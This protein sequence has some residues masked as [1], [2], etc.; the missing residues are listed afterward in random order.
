MNERDAQRLERISEKMAHMKAQKQDILSRE[1]KRQRKD[2]TRR[3]IQVGAL[4]EKHFGFKDVNP[5]EFE[6]FVT[7]LVGA[8]GGR[9]FVENVRRTLDM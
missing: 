2:R 7:A 6:K 9:E 1:K 5:L 8:K 4:A 3:L